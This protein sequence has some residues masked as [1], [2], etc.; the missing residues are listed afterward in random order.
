MRATGLAVLLLCCL[1]PGLAHAQPKP[2]NG[3]GY[4]LLPKEIPAK[5]DGVYR[6]NSY[7]D[8]YG[9]LAL[10]T[11]IFDLSFSVATTVNGLAVD[12]QNKLFL[13][14]CPAV[15]GDY[16]D[17]TQEGWIPP[18]AF[19]PDSPA[20]IK[21]IGQPFSADQ[22][23]QDI[24]GPMPNRQYDH[25]TTNYD[26]DFWDYGPYP[27]TPHYPSQGGPTPT[28]PIP[29]ATTPTLPAIPTTTSSI[30]A[31]PIPIRISRYGTGP[32]RARPGFATPPIPTR[33]CCPTSG[34]VSRGSPSVPIVLP[35]PTS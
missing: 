13:F 3:V 31:N 23:S 28:P 18:G 4:V 19:D 30:P 32:E 5:M 2:T 7:A 12:Q 35:T 1:L 26:G 6:L 15:S 24:T 25:G 9:P 34:A 8:P 20:F 29:R 10:A 14:V 33:W 27:A 17:V 22:V 21:L 16:V 11:R